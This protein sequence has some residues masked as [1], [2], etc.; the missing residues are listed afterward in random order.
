[1]VSDG[2]TDRTA[3]IAREY[4]DRHDDVRLIVFEKNRGYGAAIKE[5][6]RM[7]NGALVGFLDADGTCD[8]AFFGPLCQA[9]QIDQADLALGGRMGTESRMPLVRRIGNRLFAT[10][11]GFLSGDAVSDAASGMRVLRRDALA[12]LSPLPDGLDFTPAMSARAIMQRLRVVEKAMPYAERV[13]QSKL[14]VVK[15]GVRF[16]KAILKAVLFYRPARLFTLGFTLCLVI[17]AALAATPVE[18]Y[19]ENRR[20]E[21]WMIYRFVVCLLTGTVGLALLCAAVV[22]DEIFALR[23]TRTGWR[24][25]GSQMLHD[26]FSKPVLLL[27]SVVIGAGAAVL[28]WPGVTEY[29]ATRHVT[30]HW[31]RV[32]VSAFGF[33]IAVQCVVTASLLEMIDLWKAHL[34]ESSPSASPAATFRR[35]A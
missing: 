29:Y 13:G 5:G 34:T 18:F 26:I 6:F 23:S 9:I 3:E 27:A 7:G 11:L 17:G 21:E 12:S 15:D 16:T 30:L 4:A 33:I 32:V 24:S 2:S 22:A 31:S 28:V 10:F 35:P 19:L 14:R 20:V 8:P 25:F 1:V